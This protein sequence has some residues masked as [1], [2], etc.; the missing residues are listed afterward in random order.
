[1]KRMNFAWNRPTIILSQVWCLISPLDSRLQVYNNNSESLSW[2]QR[3]NLYVVYED[4]ISNSSWLKVKSTHTIQKYNANQK[5][6]W[7]K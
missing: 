6:A 1:M 3:K 5:F 7:G 4:T 2:F